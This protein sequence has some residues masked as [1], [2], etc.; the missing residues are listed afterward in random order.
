M[1][2]VRGG[3]SETAMRCVK[4]IMCVSDKPDVCERQTS[5]LCFRDK[6]PIRCRY[7]FYLMYMHIILLY[8][9]LLIRYKQAMLIH[10]TLTS[11]LVT[12]Q[13][14]IQGLKLDLLCEINQL[15]FFQM[16]KTLQMIG[17]ANIFC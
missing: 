12:N 11:S 6:H 14:L 4:D 9:N 13:W 16:N 1:G 5:C 2:L 7:P 3:R 8:I 15:I 17:N 10:N